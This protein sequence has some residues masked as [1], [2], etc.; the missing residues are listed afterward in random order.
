MDPTQLQ[1]LIQNLPQ[2]PGLMHKER[3]FNA[4]VLIPLVQQNQEYHFLFQKRAAQI[5]QGGE[6]SFPGGEYEP[7][8]D[9]SC[10]QAA[11]RETNEELGISR[12]KI[13]IQSSLDTFVSP[14]GITIDSFL[15]VL[16]IQG[17]QDLQPDRSEVEELFLLPVSWFLQHQPRVY[18]LKLEIHPVYT[19]QNGHKA[20]LP[21]QELGLPEHYCQPWPGMEYRVYVY[22]TPKAVVWGLT[23][24]LVHY[25][26]QRLQESPKS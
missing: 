13:H 26:V 12:D 4:A 6:I 9:Q 20:Q 11:L 16:D 7:E 14:R 8:Q 18:N 23:A 1:T 24:E 19:D 5:R 17:L 15:A 2:H 3:Y 22:Q 21:V 25:L 10:L